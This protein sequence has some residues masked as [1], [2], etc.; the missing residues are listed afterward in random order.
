[1]RKVLL[2]AIMAI[3]SVTFAQSGLKQ[4][5]DVIQSLYGKSKQ[6]LVNAY[7]ELKEPQATPFWA[8]YDAYET[9]RKAL[10]Q[11]RIMLLDDYVKNFETL[12]DAKADELVNAVSDNNIAF[13]KLFVKYYGKAK[14][15]VGAVNA[16]KFMQLEGALYTAVKAET[17]NAI[18]FVGEIDRSAKK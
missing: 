6:E 10:G 12:S 11:K 5:I 15:I 1:M 17:Q 18:P 3:S 13:E 14:K 2:I 9:E 4:D 7:M 16:V 8:M